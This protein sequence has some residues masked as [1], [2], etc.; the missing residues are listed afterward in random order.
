MHASK[1]QNRNKQKKKTNK[2]TNTY[3]Q[4]LGKINNR[5]QKH[6]YP[7]SPTRCKTSPLPSPVLTTQVEI[8]QENGYFCTRDNENGKDEKE[9][10]KHIVDAVEPDGIHNEPQFNK[11][12]AEWK[13]PANQS[14][15]PK[16]E[17]R[18]LCGT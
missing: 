16:V 14:R 9:K 4:S 10:P 7:T 12:C 13:D 15:Y 2:Q 1:Q 18:W 3:M 6:I 11:D 8:T 5:I 17:I